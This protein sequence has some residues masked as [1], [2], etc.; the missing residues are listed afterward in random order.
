MWSGMIY[1]HPEGQQ[2]DAYQK[3]D[4]LILNKRAH[5]DSLPGLEIEANEVRC[6]HGAT[7]GPIDKE[8][9]FYLMSRGLP[10]D[11]AEK[12]IVDG[13]FEPVME[14]IPLASIREQLQESVTR[15]LAI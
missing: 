2:T 1:V 4:N 7:A 6:T 5:A 8:Q 15:K 12:M 11:Q 10:Y 14:K 9:V 13:F 3:N